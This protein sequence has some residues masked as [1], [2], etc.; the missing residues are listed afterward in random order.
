MDR[1]GPHAFYVVFFEPYPLG[2]NW[3]TAEAVGLAEAG[4]AGLLERLLGH[5][6][7]DHG[8]GAGE[9]GSHNRN[10]GKAKVT[11]PTRNALGFF[12]LMVWPFFLT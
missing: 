3:R 1:P 11:V 12:I 8:L 9:P 6:G 4:D 10:P 7:A 5:R 2:R